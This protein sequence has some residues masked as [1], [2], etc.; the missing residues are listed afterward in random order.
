MTPIKRK[1]FRSGSAPLRTVRHT[2]SYRPGAKPFATTSV[3]AIDVE[4]GQYPSRVACCPPTSQRAL[5]RLY[6]LERRYETATE[7]RAPS[8]TSTSKTISPESGF[9]ASK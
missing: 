3:C 1:A 5:P 9:V 7:P 2:T 8:S 6:D 4:R